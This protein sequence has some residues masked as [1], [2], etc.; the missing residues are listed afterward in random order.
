MLSGFSLRHHHWNWLCIP[1]AVRTMLLFTRLTAAHKWAFAGL[2]VACS[3]YLFLVGFKWGAYAGAIPFVLFMCVWLLSWSG[4]L[5]GP[6]AE[7]RFV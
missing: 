1:D 3:S 4:W 7:A 2:V 6:E 5:W